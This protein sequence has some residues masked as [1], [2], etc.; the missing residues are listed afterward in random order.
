MIKKPF[1]KTNI[2]INLG[3][4]LYSYIKSILV[5]EEKTLDKK[6]VNYFINRSESSYDSLN[7][8]LK[9]VVWYGNKKGAYLYGNVSSSK[10][11]D[12]HY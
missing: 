2:K 8:W 12:G 3:Y 10:E 6:K 4:D 9:E 7:N 1:V 11:Y 5:G